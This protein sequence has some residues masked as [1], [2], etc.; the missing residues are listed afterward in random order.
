MSAGYIDE[1]H[2]AF[3]SDLVYR[4]EDIPLDC[5]PK[6]KDLEQTLHG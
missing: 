4:A 1:M 6:P 5:S 3:H 2:E